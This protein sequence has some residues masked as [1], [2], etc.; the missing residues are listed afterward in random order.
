MLASRTRTVSPSIHPRS[1][2]AVLR[3]FSRLA[4]SR[5]RWVLRP[6]GGKRRAMRPTDFCPPIELRAPAPRAFPAHWRHLRG[7]ESPWSLRLHVAL[8][9]DRT[10]HDAR[11]S[12]SADR[13]TTRTSRSIALAG[14]STNVG[15]F[16]PRRFCDRA[17]DIP[18]ANF[19]ASRVGPAFAGFLGET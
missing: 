4:P 10:F 17:S 15:V 9:G 18:V 14:W 13:Q 7:G 2:S 6:L 1:A 5:H 11:E 8:P 19:R 3:I 12:A 16:V